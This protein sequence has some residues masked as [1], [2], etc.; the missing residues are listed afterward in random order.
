MC[1][2]WRS[3]LLP[4]L[5]PLGIRTSFRKGTQAKHQARHQLLIEHKSYHLSLQLPGGLL[6]AQVLVDRLPVTLGL[7]GLWRGLRVPGLCGIALRDGCGR[8]PVLRVAFLVVPIMNAHFD[9]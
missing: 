5:T 2:Y 6:V 9:P 8:A 3:R 1:S 7:A 4:S